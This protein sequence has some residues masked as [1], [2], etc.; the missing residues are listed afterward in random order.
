MIGGR[1]ARRV[2][3]PAVVSTIAAT[4]VLV[5]VAGGAAAPPPA[6]GK[7]DRGTVIAYWTAD[8]VARAVPREVS[9][10]GLSSS[11]T[12]RGQA[13]GGRGG[14]TVS[15]AAWTGGKVKAT[16]GKVLFTMGGVDYVCSGAVAEDASTTTS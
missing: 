13:G 2:K 11:A 8:R 6:P 9:P 14:T 12:P 7:R 1:I 4:L 16:T 3:P 15:G 5:L 10:G